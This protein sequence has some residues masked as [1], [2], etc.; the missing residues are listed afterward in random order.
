LGHLPSLTALRQVVRDS[1][2]TARY[3]PQDQSMWVEA[4][5]R[6]LQL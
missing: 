2:P 5:K 6:F 3:E 1:F 4:Y